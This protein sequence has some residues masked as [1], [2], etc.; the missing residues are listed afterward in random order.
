MIV[1]DNDIENLIAKDPILHWIFSEYGQPPN[2]QRP[3][4]FVS[5][6]QIILEQ[7]VSQASAKAHFEKLQSYVGDI[8]PE[9]LILL[10][11]EAFKSCFVSRQKANYLRNI[12]KEV[13][14]GNLDFE[15][16]VSKSDIEVKENLTAIKGI[17]N[18]TANIFLMLCLQRKNISLDNDI[19]IVN[20]INKLY[21]ISLEELNLKWQPLNSLAS[22]FLWHYYLSIRK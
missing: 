19:A 2:W 22:Y 14:A 1:N 10:S 13:L 20:A 15:T 3:P 4:N 9:K 16:L 12:S 18:W 5:L 6:V 8:T 11:N 17:G 7:Q 21:K